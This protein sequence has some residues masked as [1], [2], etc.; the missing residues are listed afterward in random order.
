MSEAYKQVVEAPEEYT[1]VP[2]VENPKR[3]AIICAGLW[4]CFFVFMGVSVATTGWLNASQHGYT[5]AHIGLFKA[6]LTKAL[7]SSTSVGCQEVCDW[8]LPTTDISSE[9]CAKVKAIRVVILT[10]ICLSIFAIAFHIPVLLG[11]HAPALKKV[12]PFISGIAI[13]LVIV[14]LG[15]ASPFKNEAEDYFQTHFKSTFSL[16]FSYD[17]YLVLL[18]LLTAV[19]NFFLD[20]MASVFPLYLA[21][22]C[23]CQTQS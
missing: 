19:I 22:C 13:I 16:D 20:V 14:V 12:S 6:C 3:V 8:F 18:A 5:E 10:T 23:H 7:D 4:I 9:V 11:R 1:S 2:T 21:E 17:L 15:L